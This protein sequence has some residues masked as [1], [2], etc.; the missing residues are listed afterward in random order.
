MSVRS[1]KLSQ[2]KRVHG[3]AVRHNKLLICYPL[4]TSLELKSS[5]PLSLEPTVVLPFPE[6]AD[7][8]SSSPPSARR[9]S[10]IA[11]CGAVASAP[12]TYL[13][14]KPAKVLFA[15]SGFKTWL[16]P[17][18]A[19]DLHFI[20]SLSSMAAWLVSYRFHVSSPTRRTRMG[21]PFCGPPERFFAVVDAMLS[22]GMSVNMRRDA[23]VSVPSK[24][25]KASR[26]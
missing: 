21:L 5:L 26:G 24:K 6:L 8:D 16:M 3:K 14:S 17:C 1:K 13:I 20:S 2:P 9:G 7:A 15:L 19:F 10:L 11:G 18:R 25:K 4:L 23:A 22:T 12:S